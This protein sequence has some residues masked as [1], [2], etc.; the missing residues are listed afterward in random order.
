MILGLGFG[1]MPLFNSIFNG[2]LLGFVGNSAV[3][4]SGASIL[5]RLLPH[6]VFELP[7]IF[8]SIGSGLFLADSFTKNVIKVKKPKWRKLM[9]FG[10]SIVLLPLLIYQSMTAASIDLSNLGPGTLASLPPPIIIL[11]VINLLVFVGFAF[12]A[13]HSLRNKEVKKDLKS[14][15]K[16]LLFVILPLLIIAAIIEGLFMFLV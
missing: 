10:I 7:A 3:I 16:V 14:V 2:Y 13:V 5:F 11:A 1:A 4:E 9:I 12:V 8:I 6:G 15:G